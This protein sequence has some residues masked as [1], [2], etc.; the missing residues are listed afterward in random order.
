MPLELHT[1]TVAP[2]HRYPPGEHETAVAHAPS[3]QPNVHAPIAVHVPASHCS[4][5]PEVPHRIVPLVHATQLPAP[6]QLPPEGQSDA[7]A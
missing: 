5:P 1:S 4:M 3:L 6:L 2:S 7:G